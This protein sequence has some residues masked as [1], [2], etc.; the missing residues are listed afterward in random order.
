VANDTAIDWAIPIVKKNCFRGGNP[1]WL[2]LLW[3]RSQARSSTF[4]FAHS[5]M[6]CSLNTS[7]WGKL[8]AFDWHRVAGKAGWW[9]DNRFDD[10]LYR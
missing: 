5:G 3:A 9:R 7:N 4:S 2:W 6:G 1:E 10:W 8:I